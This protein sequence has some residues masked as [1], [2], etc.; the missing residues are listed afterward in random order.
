MYIDKSIEGKGYTHMTRLKKVE[1]QQYIEKTKN[2]NIED[3]KN[4]DLLLKYQDKFE[5]LVRELQGKFFS[6]EFDFM[7]DDHVDCKGRKNGIN[8]MDEAYV[9]IMNEKRTRLGIQPLSQNGYAQDS[10]ETL[11]YCKKLIT[12]EINFSNNEEN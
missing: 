3:K 2:L 9:K 7:L 8:P 12:Q 10:N 5:Q 4:Y 11:N 1:K 6:E